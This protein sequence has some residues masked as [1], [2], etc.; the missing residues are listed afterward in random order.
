MLDLWVRARVDL[1]LSDSEFRSLTM[2]LLFALIE[3]RE[4]VEY[5]EDLRTGLVSALLYNPHR[6]KG[7]KAMKPS[8]FFPA[9]GKRESRHMIRRSTKTKGIPAAGAQPE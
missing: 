4:E 9:S 5:R 6:K 1:S 7:A 8:D 3:R 2:R